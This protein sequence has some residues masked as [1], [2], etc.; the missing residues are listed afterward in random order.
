MALTLAN[1]T[2][3]RSFGPSIHLCRVHGLVGSLRNAGWRGDVVC[4]QHGFSSYSDAMAVLRRTCTHVFSPPLIPF[5]GGPG[6]RRAVEYARAN[7]RLPP[8]PYSK[9]QVR[10]DAGRTSLK[11]QAWRLTQYDLVL[12]TDT[13][14]IFTESPEA[15]FARA[16]ADGVVFHAQ[17]QWG[18]RGYWGISSHLM[19]LRPSAEVASVLA[20]NSAR[21]HFVPYTLGEQVH[22]NARGA[23][24]ACI[25]SL[26]AGGR[27]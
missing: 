18:G 22:S 1:G 17:R 12:H 7:G 15:M 24:R 10:H 4:L 19:L 21:G 25:R 23:S 14:V 8:P 26:P 2:D 11:L 13:D 27:H 20:S 6:G 9:V 3:H 16:H 5:D